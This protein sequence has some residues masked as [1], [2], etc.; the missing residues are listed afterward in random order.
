MKLVLYC[1]LITALFGAVALNGQGGAAGEAGFYSDWFAG[2]TMANGELV[3]QEELTASISSYP[4]DTTLRV[5]NL[6]S[7]ESVVVRVTDRPG[8]KTNELIVVTRAAAEQLGFLDSGRALVKIEVLDMGEGR[9]VEAV[10][11]TARE[12]RWIRGGLAEPGKKPS[13]FSYSQP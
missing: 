1:A 7:N 5:T 4:F 10:A 6:D 9:R 11:S 12:K 13:P 3:N 2:K 8:P